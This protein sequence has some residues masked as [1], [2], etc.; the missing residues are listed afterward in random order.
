MTNDPERSQYFKQSSPKG[1]RPNL[2]FIE[3][4]SKTSIYDINVDN[5]GAYLKSRNTSEF[6]YCDN[7]RTSIVCEDIGCK[8]Y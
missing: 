8:F 3:D 6:Y 7:D 1:I 2:F 5:N 4:I